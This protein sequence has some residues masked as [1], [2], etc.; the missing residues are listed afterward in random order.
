LKGEI[1]FSDP[2]DA[3]KESE[4]KELSGDAGSKQ[5]NC[6][7]RQRKAASNE[8]GGNGR[9]KPGGRKILALTGRGEESSIGGGCV[10]NSVRG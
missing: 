2:R 5:R 8:C 3:E 6:G 7:Q 1:F 10:G 4:V 9:G